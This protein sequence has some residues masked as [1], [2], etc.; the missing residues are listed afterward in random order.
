MFSDDNPVLEHIERKIKEMEENQQEL[1]ANKQRLLQEAQ[2]MRT[3]VNQ[4][5]KNAEDKNRM[6]TDAASGANVDE[7]L[8]ENELLKDSVEEEKKSDQ[9]PSQE[10]KK[11]KGAI[12]K[13]ISNVPL[14]PAVQKQFAKSNS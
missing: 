6:E 8:N 1:E 3:D 12:L 10:E 9:T 13:V 4:E 7:Q 2:R 14:D 5:D 11:N